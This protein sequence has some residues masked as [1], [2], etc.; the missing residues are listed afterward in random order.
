[1]EENVNEEIMSNLHEKLSTLKDKLALFDD[2]KDAITTLFNIFCT[3]IQIN[4]KVIM[5]S[6]ADYLSALDELERWYNSHGYDYPHP[7]RLKEQRE[8]WQAKL[9]K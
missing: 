9:E 7:A 8:Y 4:K 5:L 6:P 2:P 3:K 1:M